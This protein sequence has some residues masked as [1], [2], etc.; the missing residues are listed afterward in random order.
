MNYPAL[1][2][3]ILLT[4]INDLICRGV[5]DQGANSCRARIFLVC[6]VVPFLVDVSSATCFDIIRSSSGRYFYVVAL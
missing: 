4:L 5:L 1:Y 6:Y 2:F 3:S